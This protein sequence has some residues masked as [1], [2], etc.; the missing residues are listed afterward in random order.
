MKAKL[1]QIGSNILTVFTA[2]AVLGA[3][4]DFDYLLL[5]IAV[6]FASYFEGREEGKNRG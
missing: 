6:S 1:L 3:T 5:V 4:Q 2:A